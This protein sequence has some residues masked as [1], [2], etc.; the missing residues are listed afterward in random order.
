MHRTGWDEGILGSASSSSMTLGEKATLTISAYVKHIMA[1]LMHI[2]N[3]SL[4]IA[5]M[6]MARSKSFQYSSLHYSYR[7]GNC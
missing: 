5:I 3:A 7:L 2:T 6:A 4:S 1:P